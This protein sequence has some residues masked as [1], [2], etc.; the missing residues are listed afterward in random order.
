MP[1]K[2]AFCYDDV[3]LKPVFSYVD[4]RKDVDISTNLG[5]LQLQFPV[6]SSNMKTVTGFRMANAMSKYGGLGVLH[7]FD[8]IQTSI[9]TWMKCDSP[10]TIASIG[11]T[12][13]E[14]ERYL[15]YRN[16]GINYL[17]I[18]V[19]H[20][21]NIN[22]VE[23]LNRIRVFEEK[24]HRAKPFIIVGNFGSAETLAE[25]HEM[26]NGYAQCY[27]V[28]VAPGA[29]CETG[30][31]TGVASPTLS[32][33]RECA[34]LGLNIIADG[35]CKNAGDISKALA[36]GAKAVMLGSM[37]AG[38]DEAAS[39]FNGVGFKS[40]KGSSCGRMGQSDRTSEGVITKVPYI[41]SVDSVLKDI[42]GGLR[43]SMSYLNAFTLQEFRDNAV[44]LRVTS[45]GVREIGSRNEVIGR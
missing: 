37:L 19:A 3:V 6:L 42:E 43:S 1:L 14:F 26:T 10:Q 2:E 4:S 27:K 41:G 22:V 35:G 39:E 25:F 11:I 34:L 24:L 17:C 36:A 32:T 18:D 31:K 21:A 12:K 13:G 45:N 9:N 30:I 15:A 28:L 33:V 5:G 40:H 8:D 44:F 38:S 29:N 16:V 20:A 7:R 23:F